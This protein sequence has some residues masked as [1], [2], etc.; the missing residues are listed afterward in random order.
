MKL[1]IGNLASGIDNAKLGDLVSPF[2]TA[3][4]AVVVTDRDTGR[5][6]GFGFVE[7]SN[8][9][10]ARAAISGLNGKEVE[11]QALK[12]DEARP[13]KDRGRGPRR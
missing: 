10:E 6:R 2:G 7:M 11:G 1:F 9:E 4:S 13:A 8:A 5:S 3:D 12:V